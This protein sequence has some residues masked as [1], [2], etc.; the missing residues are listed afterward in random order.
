MPHRFVRALIVVTDDGV[1]RELRICSHQEDKWNVHVRDGLAQRRLKISSSFRKH[2]AIDALRQ[3]KLDGAVLFFEIVVAVAKQEVV[4]KLLRSVFGAANDHREKWIRDIGHDHADRLRF[5]LNE[6]ASD[7]IRAVVQLAYR[8]LDAL[9]QNLADVSLVVDDGG[10]GENRDAGFARYVGDACG[11]R[12]LPRFGFPRGWHTS[13]R[14]ISEISGWSK[15]HW[16]SNVQLSGLG[17]IT[18][19][20]IAFRSAQAAMNWRSVRCVAPNESNSSSVKPPSVYAR[21]KSGKRW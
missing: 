17:I 6:A 1:L 15:R 16:I 14:T 10:D 11:F 4:A 2:D 20:T 18:S 12:G 3:Q 7:Q 13:Q 21:R 5:L 8:G 19:R 9:A